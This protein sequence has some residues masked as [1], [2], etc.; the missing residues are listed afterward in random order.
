MKRAAAKIVAFGFCSVF[1]A[2][3]AYAQGL[4]DPTRPPA[5]LHAEQT[6]QEGKSATAGAPELQSVIVGPNRKIAVIN[7]QTLK[8]GDKYGD[9][10]V[11]AISEAEVVLK[12][13]D[14]SRTLKLY[15]AV[16]KKSAV[17]NAV[18]KSNKNR[19]SGQGQE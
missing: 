6:D 18:L 13:G 15:P 1:A 8:I 10:R 4:P 9:A 3:V 16:E 17:D 12:N 5:S 7:G 19:R 14:V 2:T 11:V